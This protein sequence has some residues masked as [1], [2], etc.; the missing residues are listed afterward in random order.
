MRGASG[1]VPKHSQRGVIPD[2]LR[3]GSCRSG[4]CTGRLLS[5]WMRKR[6]TEQSDAVNRLA[7]LTTQQ[8]RILQ[9]ICQGKLNKQIAFDLSIAENHGPRR[10]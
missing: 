5:C 6:D 4:L 7:T 8:S 1:Y 9:L 2:G 10:M 3:D